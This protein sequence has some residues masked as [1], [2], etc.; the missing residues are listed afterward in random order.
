MNFTILSEAA[1]DQIITVRETT[2]DAVSLIGAIGRAV[3]TISCPRGAA[4]V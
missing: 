2:A 1:A 3:R 4:S